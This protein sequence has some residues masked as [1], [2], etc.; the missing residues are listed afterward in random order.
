MA[1]VECDE[2]LFFHDFA[3]VSEVSAAATAL[4]ISRIEFDKEVPFSVLN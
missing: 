1:S 4:I 2:V 3:L